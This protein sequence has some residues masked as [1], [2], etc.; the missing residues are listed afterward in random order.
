MLGK[1][2]HKASPLGN[3]GMLPLIVTCRFYTSAT[4]INQDARRH[5]TAPLEQVQIQESQAFPRFILGSG[6][7]QPER[8]YGKKRSQYKK[9]TIPIEIGRY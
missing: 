5:A 9:A 6:A 7:P 1:Y 8:P 2:K 3:P 4:V